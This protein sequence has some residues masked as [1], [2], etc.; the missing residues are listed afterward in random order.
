LKTDPS[1]NDEAK[2]Y[3]IKMENG[4]STALELWKK[5]REL[6]ITEYKKIYKSLNVEF[7]IYSGE[8][9][10]GKRMEEE[11]KILETKKILQYNAGAAI[12][13]LKEFNMGTAMVKKNDGGSLYITRDIAA[14]SERNEKFNFVK[15]FYVVS[16]QQDLHFQQLFKLLSMMGYEWVKKCTHINFGMVKGMST[17][18]GNVVFLAD[19]LQEAKD[20]MLELM[21]KNEKKFSEVAD[22]EYT[23]FQIGLSAVFIQD[24]S[25][26]RIK[27]YEFTWE[28]VTSFEGD[29]GPYLQY[30]HARIC[31]IERKANAKGIKLNIDSN[32]EYLNDKKEASS[33]ITQIAKFPSIIQD[34]ANQTEPCV[35]VNY[36]FDL[37]HAFSSASEKLNVVQNTDKNAAESILLLFHCVRI[38]LGNGLKILGLI[39]IDRM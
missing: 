15:M 22:P 17:R 34:A 25:A 4:D 37:T 5:F 27:E 20:T 8:S 12:V 10:Y 13:D 1:L 39:P 28:R 18:R 7:D 38:T 33:L 36:L 6:S 3:F 23:A 32:L 11:F 26:R 30:A 24:L 16:A 35:L 29:T 21:K 2:A 19:I 31:S 9:Q 14:A